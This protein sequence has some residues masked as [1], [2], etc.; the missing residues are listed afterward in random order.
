MQK[1]KSSRAAVRN[2]P[3]PKPHA[4]V[5]AVFIDDYGR[6]RA[7]TINSASSFSRKKLDAASRALGR[8]LDRE[9]EQA[10]KAGERDLAKAI[11]RLRKEERETDRAIARFF[12][13][14]IRTRVIP[15]DDI[16]HRPPKRKAL[17]PSRAMTAL[18]KYN[19]PI[20]DRWNRVG[21]YFNTQYFSSRTAKPGVAKRYVTYIYRGCALDA[22]GMP[23]F[24]SNVGATIEE[25]ACGFDHLEQINRSA[26]RGAKICNY[27]ELAMD[28]RWTREQMLEV[29][30]QWAEE[31]FGRYG[32][33]YAIALHEPPPGGDSRNWHIHAMWSWRPFERVG[34]HEWLVSEGLR[35]ELD[36]AD[37]MR[38]L[39]ERF[40]ALSTLM[41]Y[42][43]GDGDVFTALSHAARGLAVEPQD[44]LGPE[45]TRR[46]R[47][48]EFVKENEENHE[49]VL[50]SKAA[51]IDD[52]LRREDERLARLQE[53]ERKVAA[54]FA[55][56]VSVP[57]VPSFAY[58]VSKI[59]TLLTAT[60][61]QALQRARV[62]D[63]APPIV[64]QT[65]PQFRVETLA[66]FVAAWRNRTMQGKFA[67]FRMRA[68]QIPPLPEPPSRTMFRPHR[69]N[70]RLQTG[71][72]PAQAAAVPIV[73]VPEVR[74]VPSSI[75]ALSRST[76]LRPVH[77]PAEVRFPPVPPPAMRSAVDGLAAVVEAWRARVRSDEFANLRIRGTQIPP[78]PEPPSRA[79]F[80]PSILKL[81][82]QAG[83]VP[84]EAVAVSMFAVPEVRAA[85]SRISELL[86][87]IALRSVN[88]PT[89]A[90]VPLEL[91]EKVT[92]GLRALSVPT[93]ASQHESDEPPVQRHGTMD[94]ATAMPGPSKPVQG[95]ADS[96]HAENTASAPE[97]ASIVPRSPHAM[98]GGSPHPPS[99]QP[100]HHVI[101]SITEV[102][103]PSA[104]STPDE[105]TIAD[106]VSRARD[107]VDRTNDQRIYVERSPDGRVFP[108]KI[109]WD[110]NRLTEAG[111]RDA[112]VQRTLERRFLHQERAIDH[113]LVLL[114]K[115]RLKDTSRESL[116]KALPEELRD[117]ATAMFKS[118]QLHRVVMETLGDR[119]KK[120]CHEA[121]AMWEEA[122]KNEAGE[123]EELAARAW[124]LSVGCER[125]FPFGQ[126]LAVQLE[127][128]AR[129]YL[130]RI[131]AAANASGSS[132]D[133]G[134]FGSNS[135]VSQ[136][137]GTDAP[138]AQAY[139]HISEP[140]SAGQAAKRVAELL[141]EIETQPGLV[142]TR[143]A[144]MLAVGVNETG[145]GPT[146]RTAFDHPQIQEALERSRHNQ[147]QF[148][149]EIWRSLVAT[150]TKS[151][152]DGGSEAVIAKLPE[153][154]RAQARPF[155]NTD[156]WHLLVRQMERSG[157]R[158]TEAQVKRWQDAVRNS[159][160]NSSALAARASGQLKKWAIP[161][162][163][164]VEAGLKADAGKYVAQVAAQQ[165]A[166]RQWGG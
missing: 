120:R 99:V 156:L 13:R 138:Q 24:H 166:A 74:A 158:R 19:G 105:D 2:T 89:A 115:Q 147:R 21:V 31:R 113:V 42:R 91:L 68:K 16:K 29:G 59:K 76:A 104:L 41:S 126:N 142:A 154:R 92:A 53:I 109:Y 107:F 163:P 34:D 83:K 162:A 50:R 14:K 40:A 143:K 118:A 44:H 37:G 75:S 61:I 69:L 149:R 5:E 25:T 71:K 6:E 159:T 152:V 122:Q 114:F 52:D 101:A 3:Q 103:S 123:R 95:R 87:N 108:G 51:T 137:H 151:D 127:A 102:V 78:P 20:R 62:P 86:R 153:S 150:V 49:R 81:L 125:E 82:L 97:P 58:A 110:G 18:P 15:A 160:G 60:N 148:V 10:I 100:Q 116:V 27:A 57:A 66:A 145:D 46:A 98:P 80:R 77:V 131:N 65:A 22:D 73:A 164:D 55:K 47:A 45:K 136:H 43:R 144:G 96:Y 23:M 8:R 165:Q 4:F 33:P 88:V 70:L 64:P 36:G 67:N 54:R 1:R 135:P 112:K 26:Q 48:G 121:A 133:G 7:L 124:Y 146:H 32:L 85:P 129:A 56:V 84:A 119:G 90:S 132:D 38:V 72:V 11:R 17:K 111:M 93:P 39:R 63:A 30:K 161:L 9:M 139:S 140:D 35:S 157:K 141:R 28:H 130:K 79:M 155:A 12:K 128:D 117:V 94:T 106:Q 134:S